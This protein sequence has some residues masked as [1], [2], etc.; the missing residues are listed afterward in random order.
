MFQ[1]LIFAE[2]KKGL[3]LQAFVMA[4]DASADAV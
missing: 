2:I 3:F 1:L 4:G